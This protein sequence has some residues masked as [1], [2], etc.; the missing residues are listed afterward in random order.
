MRI[1]KLDG[2]VFRSVVTWVL[3]CCALMVSLYVVI[4]VFSKIGE[5]MDIKGKSMIPFIA[6]YYIL[7]I[8]LILSQVL[9]MIVLCGS[10]IALGR[11]SRLNELMPMLGAGRSMYRILAP[12]FVIAIAAMLLQFAMD[13]FLVPHIA[14]RL[15]D[16]DRV[17]Q[18][19]RTDSL[20]ISKDGMGN[21]IFAESYN[22]LQREMTG[23]V[24]VRTFPGGSVERVTA[25]SAKWK[26]GGEFGVWLLS[27]GSRET[28]DAR[29]KRQGVAEKFGAGGFVLASDLKPEELGQKEDLAAYAS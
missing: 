10:A 13:E 27:N 4:D 18:G 8:P 29:G 15:V 23:V 19:D 17:R 16:T 12:V 28:R 21:E 5:F 22:R 11:M 6:R 2:Y 20:V 24:I 7:R 25:Q 26:K 3:L 14:R 1:G 9:P